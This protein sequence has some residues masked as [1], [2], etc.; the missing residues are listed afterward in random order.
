MTHPNPSSFHKDLAPQA[1]ADWYAN[2]RAVVRAGTAWALVAVFIGLAV[3]IAAPGFDGAIPVLIA[4]TVI[5]GTQP[6]P[7]P[8]KDPSWADAFQR[9]FGRDP[10]L[11]PACHQARLVLRRGFRPLR[12]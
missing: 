2:N 6:G 9:L 11:C 7:P 1:A 3:G 4:S 8:P 5:F 12:L 10:L